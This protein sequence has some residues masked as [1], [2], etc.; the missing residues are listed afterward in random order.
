MNTPIQLN[1]QDTARNR[2]R[3]ARALAAAGLFGAAAALAQP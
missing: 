3:A 2:R 1:R